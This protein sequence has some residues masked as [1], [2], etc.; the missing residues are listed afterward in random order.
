MNESE[1]PESIRVDMGV[2]GSTSA[3]TG[4]MRVLGVV[5]VEVF[6]VTVVCA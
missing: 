5:V 2:P 4:M 6:R 3:V 1:D